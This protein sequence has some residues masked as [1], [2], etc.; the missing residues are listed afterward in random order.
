MLYC[1]K[2]KIPIDLIFDTPLE[3]YLTPKDYASE[4][5]KKFKMAYK[6]ATLNR[7]KN[8]LRNKIRMDRNIRACEYAV[9]DL[10]LVLQLHTKKNE[11]KK[12]RSKWSKDVF[13]IVERTS[14]VDYIV[15]KY[16]TKKG[17]KRCVH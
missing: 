17:V 15:R 5:K 1:R 2:P 13:Q 6:Y 4:L 14:K 8:S 12:F 7:D 10:V 9:G 3:L 16:G 11:S